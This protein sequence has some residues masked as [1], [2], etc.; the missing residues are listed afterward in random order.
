M[1]GGYCKHTDGYTVR[2]YSLA[3]PAALAV[4]AAPARAVAAT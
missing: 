3:A 1:F 4:S 2:T